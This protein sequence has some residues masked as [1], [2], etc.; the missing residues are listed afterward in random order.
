MLMGGLRYQ[1]VFLLFESD[2][3]STRARINEAKAIDYGHPKE[4]HYVQGKGRLGLLKEY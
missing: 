3:T 1:V 2:E 4:T